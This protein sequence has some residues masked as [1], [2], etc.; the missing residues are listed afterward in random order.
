VG[1]DIEVSSMWMLELKY[2]VAEKVHAIARRNV[3]W[4]VYPSCAESSLRK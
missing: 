2:R 4:R 3:L 1:S